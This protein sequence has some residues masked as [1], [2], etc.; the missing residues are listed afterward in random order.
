MIYKYSEWLYTH[1]VDIQL[2]PLRAYRTINFI[3]TDW[4]FNQPLKA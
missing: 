4:Y 1:D 3:F 2:I